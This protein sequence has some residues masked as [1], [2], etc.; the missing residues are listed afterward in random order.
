MYEADAMNIELQASNDGVGGIRHLTKLR[1][2]TNLQMTKALALVPAFFTP[3]AA[4]SYKSV[5]GANLSSQNVPNSVF[6]ERSDVAVRLLAIEL[7]P[8]PQ[9]IFAPLLET[10]VSL[11]PQFRNRASIS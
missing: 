1:D 5:Y 7:A 9:S 4:N 6:Y 8:H 2:P 10:G 3:E 11:S